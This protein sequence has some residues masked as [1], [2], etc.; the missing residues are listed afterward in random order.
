MTHKDKD[1]KKLKGALYPCVVLRSQD[2]SLEVNFGHKKFKYT[3]NFILMYLTFSYFI[4][5]LLFYK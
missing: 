5:I 3:G 2:G 4:L 1:L